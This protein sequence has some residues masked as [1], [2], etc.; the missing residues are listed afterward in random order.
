[1][2]LADAKNVMA[3]LCPDDAAPS[4]TKAALHHAH[5]L[6]QSLKV[7]DARDRYELIRSLIVR[8]R[9]AKGYHDLARVQG[10]GN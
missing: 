1:M 3:E 8:V 6:G 9:I 7:N 5:L 10:R 4:S 2:F